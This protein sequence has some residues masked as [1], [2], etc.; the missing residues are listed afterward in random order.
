MMAGR[1]LSFGFVLG[2]LAMCMAGLAVLVAF[3]SSDTERFRQFL[4]GL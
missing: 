3:V 2:V 4:E 1:D